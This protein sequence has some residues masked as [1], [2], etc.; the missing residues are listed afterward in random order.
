[1]LGL[2]K[3]FQGALL[4]AVLLGTG[5]GRERP[6]LLETKGGGGELRVVLPAEP[7]DLDPNSFRDE[8][9]LLVAPNLYSRLVMLD[10]DSRIHPDL[11]KSWEVGR[12]GLEYT[13]HL[14]EGVRWHD[15]RRFKAADVR[16]TLEHLARRPSWA[17][18]ALRRIAAVE[19]PDERTVVVRLTEPWAPFIATLA[20]HGVFIL[21]AGATGRSKTPIGTGPFKFLEWIPGQRIVLTA[22]LGFFRPGPFLDR[23]VFRFQPD[24]ERSLEML[25]ANQA[26][27]VVGRPPLAILHRL[28]RDPRL[29]VV[30][31]PS[32]ARYLL[33]FNLRRSPFGDLR[34]R[35]AVNRALDRSEL[36]ARAF[37]GYGAP[38]L[39]FYTPAVAWAYNPSAR[40]PE[41]DPVQARALLDAAGLR[42]DTRGVRLEPELLFSSPVQD[43]ARVVA[44]QLRAVGIAVRLTAV[45]NGGWIERAIR[46]HDFDLALVGGNQGPDPENLNSRF[47]SRGPAQFLG[48]GNPEFDAAVAT[49]ARTVDLAQRARAYFRAQE[50][51]ARDLPVAPLA[52]SVQVTVCRREVVGL[53]R[54]EGRGLVAEQEYSLVRVHR[55]AAGGQR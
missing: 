30:T 51:L 19:T 1:M 15:G 50:I 55:P 41:F 48:Y 5:C 7:L 25:L 21:P 8:I 40:A 4:L 11:A 22:N 6:S 46:R 38:G 17:A 33:A 44:D 45:S 18:E 47:G 14:R 49:G 39:G 43:I 28:A 32:D 2:T 52:E 34:V 16:W 3:S 37:Y 24:P 36:L 10:A 13:F 26:D 53:P 54:L 35:Q 29:R 9:S 42:P 31:S 20:A 23:V 12:G 27:H